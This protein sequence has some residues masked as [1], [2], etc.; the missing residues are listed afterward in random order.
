[1]K[2]NLKGFEGFEIF[3]EVLFIKRLNSIV[4]ADTHFGYEGVMAEKGVFIPKMNYKYIVKQVEEALSKT[5][6]NRIIVNGDIKNEFDKVALEEFNEVNDFVRFCKEKGVELFLIKGNHDNFVDSLKALGIKIFKQELLVE[7]FLFFHGEELPTEENFKK[8]DFL[9][10]AHE[11]P[12]IALFTKIGIK[13]KLKCFLFGEYK[14]K[15]VVVL[16]SINF[17]MSGEEINII[18]KEELLSQFLKE[19]DLD[20]FD[21]FAEELYFG[22]IRNLRNFS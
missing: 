19:V 12:A 2:V 4:I 17:F 22:K 11:H 18:P 21:V 7:N 3:N 9:I 10:T 15:K 16:P 13:E 6:A 20:S 5:N 8:A 1:M 14:K